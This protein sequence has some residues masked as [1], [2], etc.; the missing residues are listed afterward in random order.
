LTGALALVR[1][2]WGI[3]NGLHSRRDRTLDE[4]RS[5]LRMGHAPHLLAMLNNTAIGLFALH[6]E[7]KL[8]HAQRHFA[9]QLD[10]AL[11]RLAA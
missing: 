7:K 4:D 3:E 1:E 5:Q 9:Y 11:A 2:H 6:G 10:R 8:P